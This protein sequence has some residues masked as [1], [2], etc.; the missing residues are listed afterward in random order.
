MVH[1]R[2]NIS[3]LLRMP[4]VISQTY[5]SRKEVDMTLK[6]VFDEVSS[7]VS[8]QC[9]EPLVEFLKRFRKAEV[10]SSFETWRSVLEE[11]LTYYGK[12]F[13]LYVEE[14]RK[15]F[16][17][18][19]KVSLFNFLF[20]TNIMKTY[21]EFFRIVERESPNDLIK[22]MPVDHVDVFISNFLIS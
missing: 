2:V 17:S 12:K 15:M 20:E 16:S 3:K 10:V 7:D 1:G 21:G 9:I 19:I 8:S 14:S 22:I 11:R 13:T 4:K 5:D 6:K 18:V